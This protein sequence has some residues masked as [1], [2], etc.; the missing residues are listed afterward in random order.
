MKISFITFFYRA[1]NF[2]SDFFFFLLLARIVNGKF[3]WKC[4]S[5]PSYCVTCCW[6]IPWRSGKKFS[7]FCVLSGIPRL[8][9]WLSGAKSNQRCTDVRQ[10]ELRFDAPLHSQLK[11]QHLQYITQLSRVYFICSLLI[12]AANIH[13]CANILQVSHVRLMGLRGYLWA[14]IFGAKS[15]V[16][17]E[18]RGESRRCRTLGSFFKTKL[19]RFYL[20]NS[21]AKAG[22]F[23]A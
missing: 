2:L 7:A 20:R 23:I 3:T 15:A 21:I 5:D 19:W 14:F 13:V 6:K 16:I 11:H 9:S 18:R 10:P 17:F 12:S 4:K 22:F 8:G 1:K